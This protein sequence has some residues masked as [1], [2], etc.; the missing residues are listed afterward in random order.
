MIGET[1]LAGT[2][3]RCKQAYNCRDNISLIIGLQSASWWSVNI[4]CA[5]CW[6]TIG[7]PIIVPPILA[8]SS[9][10]SFNSANPTWLPNQFKKTIVKKLSVRCGSKNYGTCFEHSRLRTKSRFLR[11]HMTT[12][13]KKWLKGQCA[14]SLFTQKNHNFVN[15]LYLQ[16][17]FGGDTP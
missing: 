1:I 8:R 12:C 17:K 3:A 14:K 13:L 11:N 5:N 15:F 16:L 10:V 7:A 2:S 9:A 6:P 4:Y